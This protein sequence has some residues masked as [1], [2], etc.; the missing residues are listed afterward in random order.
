[1]DAHVSTPTPLPP[2][3][4]PAHRYSKGTCG[5]IILLLRHMGSSALLRAL[6]WAAIAAGYTVT[7][8]TQASR[9]TCASAAPDHD[10]RSQQHCA[11]ARRSPAT[12]G[13]R[14]VETGTRSGLPTQRSSSSSTP[15]H[16]TP[17]CSPRASASSFGSISRS[18]DTG[19]LAPLR[20]TWPQSG[21]MS[22][23]WRSPL[24]SYPTR[25]AARSASARRSRAA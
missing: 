15:I 19:S 22:S 17:S 2:H 1:M 20:R 10:C 13:L 18:V 25:P 23:R 11:F 9:P 5:P 24:T 3:V 21:A 14:F 4:G 12:R 8:H 6:P 16:T 7:L